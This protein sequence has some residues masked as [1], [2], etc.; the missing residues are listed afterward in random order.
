MLE[1]KRNFILSHYHVLY[2]LTHRVLS[3][4][5][6]DHYEIWPRIILSWPLRGYSFLMRYF[7]FLLTI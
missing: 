2:R 4:S 3:D 7:K 5:G 6:Y 1:N